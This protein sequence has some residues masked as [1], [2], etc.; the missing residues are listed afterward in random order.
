M[1]KYGVYVI[2]EIGWEYNDEYYHRPECDGGTL[3]TFYKA[4]E[5]ALA[6]A[7]VERLNKEAN[8]NIKDDPSWEYTK[9]QDGLSNDDELDF[10][11]LVFVPYHDPQS[12]I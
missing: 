1:S 9:Q 7:E 6:E 12:H 11:E 2:V 10:F 5:K 3:K 4:E 8:E